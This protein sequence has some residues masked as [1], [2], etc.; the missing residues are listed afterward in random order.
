MSTSDDELIESRSEHPR[1]IST[2]TTEDGT[3][4]F[5][6]GV[7]RRGYRSLVWDGDP[8]TEVSYDHSRHVI[9]MT[10]EGQETARFDDRPQRFLFMERDPSTGKIRPAMEWGSPVYYHLA[11]ETD[12]A[13]DEDGN[14]P[15]V[16]T[17]ENL[18]QWN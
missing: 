10:T 13:A 11:K 17:D 2:Y 15:Q 7:A 3:H 14:E 4:H 12:T 8:T 18:E 5:C 9:Q 16:N 6:E 1:Y